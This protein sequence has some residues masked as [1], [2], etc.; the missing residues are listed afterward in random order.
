[1]KYSPVTR[2]STYIQQAWHFGEEKQ[3]AIT[4]EQ[5]K[6]APQISTTQWSPLVWD[7]KRIHVLVLRENHVLIKLRT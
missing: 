1:M 3:P 2:I 4:Q 7:S 5:M 6:I